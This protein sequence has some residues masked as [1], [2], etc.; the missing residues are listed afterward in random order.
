MSYTDNFVF[1]KNP[2][3]N[4]IMNEYF[5]LFYLR[6]FKWKEMIKS[7]LNDSFY[8]SSSQSPNTTD[9]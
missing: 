4:F 7:F 9:I 1:D 3:I 5:F 6:L 8:I 2:K